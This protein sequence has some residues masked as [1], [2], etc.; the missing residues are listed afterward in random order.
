[1]DELFERLSI[2]F[3]SFVWNT[4]GKKSNHPHCFRELKE[5]SDGHLGLRSPDPNPTHP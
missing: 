3:W 2:A 4:N 5:F 1:L